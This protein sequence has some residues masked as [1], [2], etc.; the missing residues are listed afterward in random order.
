MQSSNI[1]C[2]D[3]LGILQTFKCNMNDFYLNKF[4]KP[5]IEWLSSLSSDEE[6][7]SPQAKNH[8]IRIKNFLKYPEEQ[9]DA[10]GM[11]YSDNYYDTKRAFICKIQNH[12]ENYLVNYYS[13]ASLSNFFT[14]IVR[15]LDNILQSMYI[16]MKENT[17]EKQLII[18]RLLNNQKCFDIRYEVKDYM[19]DN[20][21]HVH[22][23]L[24]SN[25]IKT[26]DRL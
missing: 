7:Y 8:I 21:Y 10:L 2:I 22:D 12:D 24:F 26:Y 1:L 16:S 5:D 4:L 9:L 18:N 17:I 3:L 11:A 19:F 15:K 14:N 6:L 20:A 25:E 13:G 23:K